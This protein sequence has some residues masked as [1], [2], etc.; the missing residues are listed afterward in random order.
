M[1][2]LIDGFRLKFAPSLLRSISQSPVYT[3]IP[4]ICEYSSE[5]QPENR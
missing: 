1:S 4:E 5:K 3:N 2:Q